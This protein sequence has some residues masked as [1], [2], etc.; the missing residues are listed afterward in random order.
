MVFRDSRDFLCWSPRKQNFGP[1]TNFFLFLFPSLSISA[2]KQFLI[3]RCFLFFYRLVTKGTVDENVY[4]IAKRKLVLDAAVL[5]SGEEVKTEGGD[6][7]DN[8][9]MGEILSSLLLGS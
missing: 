5:K 9:T 4:E 8:K 3:L 2:S 7:P 1:N 6:M